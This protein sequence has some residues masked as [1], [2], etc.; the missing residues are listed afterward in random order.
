MVK[1]TEE[2][3][4]TIKEMTVEETYKS[5]TDHE[6]ILKLPDTYIGGIEEDNIKMWVYENGKIVNKFI[7]YIPGL[8]KI[9]DEILVNARD[10]SIRDKTCSEIR[11]IISQSDEDPGTIKVW[12]NGD[13]GIPVEFHKVEKCYVPEMIFG[14]IRTS[15]NYE[16]K[17][18]IVGGRNGLG[19]K[20]TNIYS[21]HFNVEVVDAKRMTKFTQDF[22]NNMY[23]RDEAKIEKLKGKQKSYTQ[24]SFTP[25]YKR[26][27][28][29][30]LSDD[31]LNLF[32]KRVYDL[33][34][35]TNI[36]V[37]LNDTLITVNS[38]ESY[39]KMFYEEDELPSNPIY[40]VV[41]DRWKVGVIYDPNNG[42]RQ[43]SYV[44]GICTFQGGSH[45]THVTNQIIEN[46]HEKIMAKNKG[47]KLKSSTIKDNL[48]FFIDA[49]IEDPA[50]S[51]Q[52][53]EFLTT[54]VAN[55][56][57]KCNI[58]EK[59]IQQICKTGL[60]EDVI[61]FAKLRAMADLAKTS[62]KKK[63]NLKGLFKLDD[64]HWAGSRKADQCTLILTE[65]D[66]AKAHGTAGIEILGRNKYGIFPLR[67][68]LLNVR[69]ATAKQLKEN[70]E[71]KNIVQ[72]MGLKYGK[73]YTSVTQLRY[74]KIMILTDQ[75]Y[76]G[77]HIKGLLIN[78]I[79]FFWPSLLR[80]KGFIT[81][82]RT[83]II[84]V[85]KISDTNKKN[86]KL[87]Y[88]LTDYHEWKKTIT[89]IKLYNVKYYKGLGTH[90][91]K[92][93]KEC[94]SE[95]EQNL[96]KYIWNQTEDDNKK[97]EK[98]D[99]KDYE[100]EDDDSDED[101]DNA[102][103][104]SKSSLKSESEEDYDDD[105]NN[106]SFD[107]ITMAF[108]KNRAHDRKLWLGN[109]N[110][111]TILETHDT[112]V[113]Y[114][115]FI[116][117]DLI[118]FSNYDN[119][120]SIPSI[121][122]GFKPSLRKILFGC[123]KKNIF[124]NE[125]K[126]AQL[127]GFVSDVAGY[128]HGEVSLQGAI[129]GM[130]QN[131]PGSNNIYWL[132]PNGNFGNRK[133][134]GKN[135]AS[136][137]YIYTQLNELVPFVFRKEDECIYNYLD[138]DGT[139]VEPETYCPIICNTLINPIAGIGTG[140][141]TD[142]PG[143]NPLDVINNQRLIIKGE[144]PLPITPWCRGFN[145]K[146]IKI[147]DKS[148]EA[149]G[150]Y[151]IVNENTIRITE[152]PPGVWT[153]NYKKYLD[154]MMADDPKNPKKGQ[155]VKKFHD[156]SGN[157]TVKFTIELFD[158]ILQDL[159]KKNE[160]M[161]KFKLVEKINLTNMNLYDSHGM[162]R[163]YNSVDDIL[164]EYCEFRLHM[165]DL[166]KKYYMRFLENQLAIL[167]YRIKFINDVISGKI[168]VF[169]KKSPKSE[170]EVITQ[171][172]DNKYPK[173]STNVNAL[174]SEKSYDYIT[175]LGLFSLTKNRKEKLEKEYNDKLEEYN[176][177]KNTT[178]ETLWLRELDELE[179]AYHKWYQRTLEED[180]EDDKTVKGKGAKKGKGTIKVNKKK[181][182]VVIDD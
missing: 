1:K 87:F 26:F 113:T 124:K 166:R 125:I 143:H 178:I 37:Y 81:S 101:N 142:I 17:G 82:L 27:G 167:N 169:E 71:I 107:A 175:N 64:A 112:E 144:K 80:I 92:E 74:G 88:T 105:T 29:E 66:S 174:E 117:K 19:A 128:H 30:K 129:V 110:K 57:S 49:I 11:I 114:K 116:D 123:F 48:T 39:I 7:K 90:T 22:Y 131:F 24:I 163:K 176:I 139:P 10:Q 168:I 150:I 59:F 75:D 94:F 43:I 141:S 12:N 155:I 98:I 78:F 159:I 97:T 79:H 55:F 132:L 160:V 135:A 157:F 106:E 40:E 119:I 41:N 34:A 130:A 182:I 115:E 170:E 44:N 95:F 38:L 68:K 6:H 173:L 52:T 89:N 62:G 61:N 47:L 32:K 118:H 21:Q 179:K 177:Y 83:P 152:L 8:Y 162:L 102:S 154:S 121:C 50:F 3:N 20:A 171:C 13:N 145:G 108:S 18:K 23:K 93:A 14:K 85:W 53:K 16:E 33:A 9:Y 91:E 54:K 149:R 60:I 86:I 67:G 45:V 51:S 56:G 35:V 28:V 126:V 111:N 99:L 120:R 153:E 127:A 122:D 76:D 25:D 42:F 63:E 146:I 140:F 165:Y 31:M 58:S 138:D 2:S 148:F 77:S 65:G 172:E 46:V 151:D 137:R 15:S 133:Q 103:I 147:A 136:A 158:G 84:K 73:K 36:K 100:E 96:I 180:Q 72:I 161:K 164:T 5:M 134:G 4:D 109:Y 156:D 104:K 181:N 69:E 70:E